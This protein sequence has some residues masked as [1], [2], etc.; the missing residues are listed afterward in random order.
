MNEHS[1]THTHIHIDEN[2][3]R[4]YHQIKI[5]SVC[6]IC[7]LLVLLPAFP[8]KC[9]RLLIRSVQW[10]NAESPFASSFTSSQA[11]KSIP[12][13]QQKYIPM[14]TV[15]V[16]AVMNERKTK[17]IHAAHL[18]CE[19]VLVWHGQ[20]KIIDYAILPVTF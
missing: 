17:R 19:C 14:T 1:H 10:C 5:G 11:H 13:P 12:K 2:E 6:A 20:V 18:L 7:F 16:N 4:Q 9:V 3:T 15:A 8:N